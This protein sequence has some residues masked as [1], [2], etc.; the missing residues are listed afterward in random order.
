MRLYLD[1]MISPAVAATLGGAGHDVVA[2]VERGALGAS[3]PAQFARAI[4]ERRALVTYDIADFVTLARAAG[5][6]GR[7]HWGLV[8]V[9]DRHLPPS[10]IGGLIGA[11]TVL[12]ERHPDH[13]ALK[14]RIAFL[15]RTS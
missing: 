8:M 3:D 15:R 11:L 1:E 10:D 4:H 5:A 12:L 7:D 6:A 2:V 13:D 14:N 9:D